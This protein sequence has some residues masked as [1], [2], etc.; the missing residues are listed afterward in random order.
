M[1]GLRLS[2]RLMRLSLVILL[3]TLLASGV[4]LLQRLL[5]RDLMPLRQRLTRWF[6]RRLSAALPF[7]VEVQGELPSTPALWVSNHISWSDI[8]L[9][10]ALQPLSFLSKAEVSHWPVL[11]FLARAAGTQFIQRGAGDSG[12]VS[13]RLSEQLQRGRPLLIFPE[14][15]TTEGIGVR[16]FHGRL[17]ASAIES[18]VPLQPVAIRYLRHGRPCPIAPFVGDDPMGA[19][20]LRLL[21][22][23]KATVQIRLLPPIDS[24]GLNRNELARRSQQA[25]S[26]ALER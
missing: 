25:V 24:N 5:R 2:W 13:A 17:L 26:E 6:M 7:H 3:G 23:P 16:T 19:H 20:L 12:L 15:T 18:G 11:G 22:A 1:S 10:G 14:G 8:P 21:S 9:L 4:S